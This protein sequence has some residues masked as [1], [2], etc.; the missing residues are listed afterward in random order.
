MGCLGIPIFNE[1]LDLQYKNSKLLTEAIC[2][3]IKQQN[4]GY[5]S[6][7]EIKK[8]KNQITATRL[9]GHKLLLQNLRDNMNQQRKR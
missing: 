2:N 9:A 6:R 1:T 5:E 4:R 8:I 3:K 7:E